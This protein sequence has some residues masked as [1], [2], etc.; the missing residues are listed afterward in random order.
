MS[1]KQQSSHLLLALDT[2]RQL[3]HS[4][5]EQLADHARKWL[6]VAQHIADLEYLMRR[7]IEVAVGPEASNSKYLQRIPSVGTGEIHEFMQ[8]F[9]SQG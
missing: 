9:V 6:G 2:W 8:N 3:W 1:L 5:M 4:T 7:T